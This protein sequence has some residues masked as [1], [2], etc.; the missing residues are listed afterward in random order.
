MGGHSILEDRV[1]SVLNDH[2]HT[3]RAITCAAF[4]P[5]PRQDAFDAVL[6]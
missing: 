3:F 4:G 1:H 5:T 2:A 6:C